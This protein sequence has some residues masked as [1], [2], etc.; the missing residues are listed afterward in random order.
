MGYKTKH[1]NTAEHILQEILLKHYLIRI[2]FTCYE[3]RP[4]SV[5]Y[6]ESCRIYWDW[7]LITDM[8]IQHTIPDT[9]QADSVGKIML[10]LELSLT[11]KGIAMIYNGKS[12][13]VWN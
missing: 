8:K 2:S 10:L 5:T 9:T 1:G 7:A 6:D 12:I 4:E 11:P 13:S 3:C